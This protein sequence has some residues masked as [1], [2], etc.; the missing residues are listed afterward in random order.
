MNKLRPSVLI[1]LGSITFSALSLGFTLIVHYWMV[2]LTVL[3]VIAIPLVSGVFAYFIFYYLLKQF[4][5]QRLGL[6]YRSIRNKEPLNASIDRMVAS[7]ELDVANWEEGQSTEIIKLK[8]QEAFRREFLGNLAHELKTPVFSIQGYILTLLDG[9]LDNPTVNK[10]FLERASKAT[11]RMATI[12]DDLDHIT[13]LEVNELSLFQR[14]FDLSELVTEIIDSLE[15]LAKEKEIQV[16]KKKDYSTIN[17]VGDREKIGQVFTNLIN[18]AIFYGN[19]GGYCRIGFNYFD[20][21]IECEISDD[22]PGIDS[23]HLPR[24]F[25]R[26]YRVEKSRSRNEGGSGLGLAIA[27]HIIESH[28]HKIL[29]KSTIGQ[30]S[31]FYFNLNRSKNN[32][33]QSSRG[34]PL[35]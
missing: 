12:L 29:V 10:S 32:L 2:R 30:G 18:N 28:G 15:L 9:G 14:P 5:Q 22:G 24:I 23:S 34:V 3:L 27:K 19:K 7:A 20:D 13:Q 4:I 6:I 21:I 8:E 11:D 1:L 25:E 16:S 26:F 35:K 31:N 17:V 33:P